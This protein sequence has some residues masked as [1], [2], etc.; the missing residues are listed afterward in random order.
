MF[1]KKYIPAKIFLCVLFV[2]MCLAFGAF[3]NTRAKRALFPKE[4]SRIKIDWA[5]LYPFQNEKTQQENIRQETKLEGIHRYLVFNAKLYTTDKLPGYMKFVEQ[6][7]RYEN[8]I[9]WN[10]A[11][12]AGYNSVVKLKDGYLTKFIA[13]FD[14]TPNIK[15]TVELAKFC[16]DKN[17]KFMYVQAPF[18]ICK[19]ED[20]EVSGTLDYSNNVAD[21]LLAGLNNADVKNLDVRKLLHD[22]G[23]SHHGSYYRTDH[24]WKPDTALW[25]SR[26]IIKTMREDFKWPVDENILD[27]KNF[28]FKI[29]PSSLLGSEGKKLTA[30]RVKL[31]DAIKITPNFDTLFHVDAPDALVDDD[32]NFENIHGGF[33]LT[34]LTN[35]KATNNKK[36]LL[37]GDSFAGSFIGVRSY[38]ALCV[39]KLDYIDPRVFTGSIRAYIEQTKPDAVIVLYYIGSVRPINYSHHESTFDF[40]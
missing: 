20:A 1:N 9:G 29:T 28:N 30:V 34:R 25:T 16:A 18:K 12:I 40:R 19:Y 13:S 33:F 17:I 10:M 5:K 8:L 23:K 26:H 38:L 14:V 11:P 24:H 27:D 21:D 15:S 6:A 36:I 37:I 39:N 31:E 32:S 35:L 7:R 3:I 2:L 22:E 4:F